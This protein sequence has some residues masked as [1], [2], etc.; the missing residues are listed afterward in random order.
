VSTGATLASRLLTLVANKID[1]PLRSTVQNQRQCILTDG[2][3]Q[4]RCSV[5]GGPS[6]TTNS[7]NTN[8]VYSLGAVVIEHVAGLA[9]NLP[10]VVAAAGRIGGRQDEQTSDFK[11]RAGRPVT[12]IT[13]LAWFG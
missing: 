6:A 9:P 11:R 5:P 2:Q 10:V 12:P 7:D 4:G 8:G 13:S 3:V 1:P